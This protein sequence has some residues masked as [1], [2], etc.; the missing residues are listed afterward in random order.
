M[1]TI[2]HQLK[3]EEALSQLGSNLEGGLESAEAAARLEK[4]GP[5]ELI[6]KGGKGGLK[7]LLEQLT[8]IMVIILVVSAVISLFLQDYEDAIAILAIVILNTVLGFTQEYKAEKAMEALKKMAVP[9]VKVRRDGHLAEISARDLVPGDIIQL[10]AGNSI[11]ADGR[12]LESINLR[13][14]EA[15]LTGESEAVEKSIEPLTGDNL[16]IGDR[17]NSIFSGTLVTYGRG[18]AVITETGMNTELGNIATMLQSVGSESTPLQKK[19]AQVGKY[20]AMA[21]LVIVAV[22][23]LLGVLRGDELRLLFMTAISMA[24]AAVPEGLPT[25][26]TI[27]LSLGAQRMLKRNALIRKLPAVETLGSVTVIC[28]DKTGTL[29]ENRMTVTVLDIAG[30]QMDL[31][32]HMSDFSPTVDPK[33]D[34]I[35]ALSRQ[36]SIQ[37]LL[38]GGALCNDATLEPVNQNSSEFS[39]IGD[40]TE[41]AL[42]IAAAH[43]GLWKS[44]L[45]KRFPRVGEMPFDSDRKRMTTIHSISD[46]KAFSLPSAAVKGKNEVSH[47]AFTKGSV[48]GLLAISSHVACGEQFEPMNDEWRQRIQESNDRLAANGMRILGICCQLRTNADTKE[49]IQPIEK[50]LIFI[51]LVG[52]IDPARSEV[53][54]AVQTAQQ[55]GVRSVMITGD[56]PLTAAFIARELGI[57]MGHDKNLVMTGQ[58][59]DQLSVEELEKTVEDVVVYAR[60]S[61]EHK[62]KIVQALQRLG[63]IVAMTG[64][65]VN[66]APALKKADIGVAMGITGT[67][68]SK[69]AADMVLLDDNF[70]T[71]VAAVEEGRRIYDNIRKFIKYA[72]T[73]NAGEIWV[74]LA[75]PFLGM[76]LPLLPLQI[77]WINLVTDGLPGLAMTVEAAE[78]DVMKRPPHNPKEGIFSRGLGRDILWIGLL[79]GAVSLG[80]GY[81]AYNTGHEGW[82]TMIFTTVTLSQMGNA[83]ALRSDRESVFKL[84]LFSNKLLMG[85]IVLTT[86]LQMAVIYIPFLQEIF[87]TKPL[88]A[89]DLLISLGLSLVVFAAV[90]LFKWGLRR[91]TRP[92]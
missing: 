64:D 36:P 65:G 2:W 90:E 40:P 8:G 32:E 76:P 27:A 19:L 82:Q 53:K 42:V 4:Y 28:S 70:A 68:V 80:M 31:Q 55:A 5:N 15:V 7:I 30:L 59:L 75:A 78:K 39:A 92:S 87:E 22:V 84:G 25:V 18:T 49:E 16:V 20:L 9:R 12:M 89:V 79:M 71:I 35:P 69:E 81:W 21:A 85:S 17:R 57:L 60:V 66:D 46:L 14:Q 54:A 56:H 29:T 73:S 33:T 44:E 77:L 34:P 37:L 43:G 50:D 58:E 88:S 6:D 45:D 23:F 51:G 63:H 3:G 48:D 11:P 38:M 67:D 24:V 61:P 41:G 1:K 47:L 86:L 10:E 83:L 26:V 52:M 62:L 74:M 72:L 13:I 91:W